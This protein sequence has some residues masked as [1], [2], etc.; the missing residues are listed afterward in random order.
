[1][2]QVTKHGAGVILDPYY[3]DKEIV[4]NA[5]ID[6]VGNQKLVY[7][8]L[9]SRFVRSLLNMNL[10]PK[11]EVF[12]CRYKTSISKLKEVVVDPII[13]GPENAIW[14]T[15]YVLRHQG[16]RHL[17]SPAVGVTLAQ[18]YFLDLLTYVII[19][20]LIALYLTYLLLRLVARRLIARVILAR[21][22]NPPAGKFKAL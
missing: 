7:L 19:G 6:V 12:H 10:E 4:K 11:N 3:L 9:F 20:S 8:L 14:W 13:S 17:R 1:M 22:V 2:E 18:Y 15:E 21:R 16:A 5:I